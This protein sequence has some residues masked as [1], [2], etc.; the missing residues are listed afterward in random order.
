M[1]QLKHQVEELQT[2]H[3][4]LTKSYESLRFEC[5]RIKREVDELRDDNARLNELSSSS[6]KMEALQREIPDSVIFGASE[7]DFDTEKRFTEK[8]Y[9]PWKF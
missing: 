5:S 4:E 3:E 8:T 6:K 2:Q 7:P 1:A 9:P